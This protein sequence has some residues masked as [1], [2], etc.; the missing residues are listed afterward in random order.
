MVEIRAINQHSLWN[1]ICYWYR[2]SDFR[3][4]CNRSFRI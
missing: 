3:I 1:S 2:Y 4:L